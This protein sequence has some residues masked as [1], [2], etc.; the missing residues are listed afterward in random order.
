MKYLKT[1]RSSRSGGKGCAHIVLSD[2]GSLVSVMCENADGFS[3]WPVRYADGSIAYDYP[4][5]MPK[6]VKRCVQQA[7]S[8][9]YRYRDPIT[10]RPLA[11]DDSL[12]D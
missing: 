4:E 3:D 11:D 7:F 1:F 9:I 5:R 6:Y 10:L 2:D 12:I 8:V